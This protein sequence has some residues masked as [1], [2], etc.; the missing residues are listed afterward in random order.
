MCARSIF[1]FELAMRVLALMYCPY[2]TRVSSG[3]IVAVF[4]FFHRIVRVLK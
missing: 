2:M 4:K 3:L 1:T